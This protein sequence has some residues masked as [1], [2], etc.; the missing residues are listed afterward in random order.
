MKVD[1]MIWED[2]NIEVNYP[3]M[4]EGNY[5]IGVIVPGSGCAITN[6]LVDL[7]LT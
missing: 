2:S 4:R 5:D 3:S 1:V 7:L 6:R